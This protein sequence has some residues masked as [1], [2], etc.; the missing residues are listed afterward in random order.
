[1]RFRPELLL[2]LLGCSGVC[3]AQSGCFAT[4]SQAVKRIGTQAETGFRV[5]STLHDPLHAGVW[6]QVEQCGHPE[7]PVLLV[8]V[9]AGAAT[10]PREADKALRTAADGPHL[11]KGT[12][13]SSAQPAVTAGGTVTVIQQSDLVQLETAGVALSNAAVGDL[14]KVRLGNQQFVLG[15]VRGAGVV[16][17]R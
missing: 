16:E 8:R 3:G 7:W 13:A 2:I 15:T 9:P 12:A 6:A 14:V 10:W 17:I 5:Q 4:P 11:P 1:M